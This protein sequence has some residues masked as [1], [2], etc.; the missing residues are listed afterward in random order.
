MDLRPVLK[1]KKCA[2]MLIVK[3][4]GL[5]PLNST[6][7]KIYGRFEVKIREKILD[8]SQIISCFFSEG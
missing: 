7:E 6:L 5:I 3:E 1:L 8:F 2:Q 4:K